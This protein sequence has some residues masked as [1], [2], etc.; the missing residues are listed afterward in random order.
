MQELLAC[1]NFETCGRKAAIEE[2]PK[3]PFRKISMS[4]V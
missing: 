3:H 1:E 4:D 2:I